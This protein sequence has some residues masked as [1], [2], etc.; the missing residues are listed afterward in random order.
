MD[1][2]V[3]RAIIRDE[4]GKMD[5]HH[6]PFANCI[7]KGSSHRCSLFSMD[8]QVLIRDRAH[9]NGVVLIDDLANVVMY[10]FDFILLPS[11]NI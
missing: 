6:I 2:K 9:A 11:F 4:W 10:V 8:F 5:S 1:N 7:F 3:K